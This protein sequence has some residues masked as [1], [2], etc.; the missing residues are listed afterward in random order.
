MAQNFGRWLTFLDGRGELDDRVP[1]E[2]LVTPARVAAYLR[3]LQEMGY[4]PQSIVLA[5]SGISCAMK[6]FAPAQDWRWIW[7]PN[8]VKLAPRLKG[9]RKEFAVPHPSDLYGWG[10]ELLSQADEQKRR[11]DRLAQYRDGLMICLLAGRAI[12]RR[13]FA[14]MQIGKHLY[15]DKDGW[16]LKFEPED[17]KNRRWIEVSAPKTLEPWIDRYLSEIRPALLLRTKKGVA[18]N[19][20]GKAATAL[21]V[22]VDGTDLTELGLTSV[23]WN[24]SSRKFTQPFATHRF[25]HAVG[26]FDPVEDPEH[27]GIATSLL[28]IGAK[29]HEKHYNRARDHVAETKFHEALAKE[30]AK[31]V[32]LARRLLAAR[33]K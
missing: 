6:V 15:R 33:D 29:M 23:I 10:L 8:G 11:R 25:R 20:I 22:S 26:T 27:P 4:H 24:S 32:S 28:A 13:S 14:A 16:R 12:R 5:I 1:P 31:A 18:A 19:R 21:W 17:V 7:A 2:Q 3:E 9:R 30:R